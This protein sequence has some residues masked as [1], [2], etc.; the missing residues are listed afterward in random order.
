MTSFQMADMNSQYLVAPWVLIIHPDII[1]GVLQG[2]V[3][4][5]L[6]SVHCDQYAAQGLGRSS[7]HWEWAGCIGTLHME[8]AG[9]LCI[10]KE[11]ATLQ[12]PNAMP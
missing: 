4:R 2:P 9:Q 3:L 10:G 5:P 1:H 7:S 11:T 6:A 12:K 8:G